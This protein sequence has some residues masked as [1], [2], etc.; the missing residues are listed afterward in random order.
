VS[1]FKQYSLSVYQSEGGVYPCW[2]H[3]EISK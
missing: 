3:D 1:A 2:W